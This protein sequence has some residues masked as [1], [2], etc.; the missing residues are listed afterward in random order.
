MITSALSQEIAMLHAEICSA[1]ADPRRILMLYALHDKPSNVGDLA[2]AL[3]VKQSTASRHLNILRERGLALAQ[4]EGQSVVYTLADPRI[5]QVL[6]LLRAVLAS[7]LKSQA[8]LAESVPSSG[9]APIEA[10]GAR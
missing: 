2:Q 6:D 10:G 3:G 8:A 1:L 4:R 5:I 7:R 9:E